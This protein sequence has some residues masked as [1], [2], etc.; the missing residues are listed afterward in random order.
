ML[1]Y[2]AVV[3]Q[4]NYSA[5]A[6]Q[7]SPYTFLAS[8]IMTAESIVID[9]HIELQ[10]IFSKNWIISVAKVKKEKEAEEDKR[11]FFNLLLLPFQNI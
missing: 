2:M 7:S 9:L 11:T 5:A 8:K 4:Q 3:R 6:E 1:D 10:H